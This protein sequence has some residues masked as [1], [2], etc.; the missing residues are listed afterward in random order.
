MSELLFV[1][2]RSE[3]SAS[4]SMPV[5]VL[6]ASSLTPC[7]DPA[8]GAHPRGV[9][10]VSISPD[11][12][13]LAVALGYDA[14]YIAVFSTATGEEV[15][16]SNPPLRA[17][18]RLQFSPDGSKLAVATAD[19]GSGVAPFYIYDTATWT[20]SAPWTMTSTVV[21]GLAFSPDSTKLAITLD[22]AA[23]LIRVI[24]TTTWVAS[25]PS[26]DPSGSSIKN[27]VAW[28]PD[29]AVLAVTTEAAANRVVLFD[30][31]T[32][33]PIT[34]LD[35]QPGSTA[36]AVSFSPNGNHLAV[37]AGS[38]PR[39]IIYDI[40]GLVWTS[41][42]PPSD[43]PTG[44][45]YSV[46]FSPDSAKIYTGGVFNTE[47]LVF[48]TTTG[49][50]IG[51][52]VSASSADVIRQVL[53]T[54][55]TVIAAKRIYTTTANPIRNADGDPFAT[56]VR[57]YDRASGA[58]QGEVMAAGDGTYEL[59]PYFSAREAQVVFQAPTGGD[60]LNDQIHRVIP[61]P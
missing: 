20:R 46:E 36:F 16:I 9:H 22:G 31:A 52:T 11:G 60:L 6:A 8:P 49:A 32:F 61:A 56:R 14:P 45:V 51:G 25:A 24:N 28:S 2:L 12:Q 21:N 23:R 37:G 41:R 44:A 39:L 26:S 59:G 34:R 18:F 19:Y 27:A 58:I 57:A 4:P 54:S 17:V 15:T 3:G 33:S 38:A 35:V 7:L 30:S 10:S 29:G 47:P 42:S 48:N 13:W 55:A 53:A 50:R 5:K 40:D 1:A 43:G